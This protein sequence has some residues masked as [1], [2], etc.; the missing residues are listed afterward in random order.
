VSTPEATQARLW[1][2]RAANLLFAHTKGP[3]QPLAHLT[4]IAHA[5]RYIE[6][7]RAQLVQAARDEGRDWGQ[8]G[9]ALGVSRQAVR[10]RYGLT[11][12]DDQAADHP[13]AGWTFATIEQPT[14]ASPAGRGRSRP[15]SATGPAAPTTALPT[16]PTRR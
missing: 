7:A 2:N 3:Q 16:T 8:I 6:D 1:L 4:A 13:L 11:D 10:Q 14:A 5:E 9:R 12:D 15:R